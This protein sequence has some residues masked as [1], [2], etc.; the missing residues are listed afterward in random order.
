MLS[1]LDLIADLNRMFKDQ[2]QAAYEIV[3]DILQAEPDAHAKG[4]QC[5][6]HLAEI[7]T[8][9]HHREQKAKEQHSVSCQKIQHVWHAARQLKAREDLFRKNESKKARQRVGE[10]EHDAKHHDVFYRNL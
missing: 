3:A 7:Y 9:G 6:C 8:S 10:S 5:K 1:D 2:D 4:T